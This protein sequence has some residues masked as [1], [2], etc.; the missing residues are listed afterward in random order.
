[1]QQATQ[2]LSALVA[3]VQLLLIQ[4]LETKEATQYFQL[5]L[6]KVAVLGLVL[7]VDQVIIR[8]VLVVLVV[9]VEAQVKVLE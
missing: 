6:P 2:L 4:I 7:E 9:Q 8:L 5:S 1:V 3:L